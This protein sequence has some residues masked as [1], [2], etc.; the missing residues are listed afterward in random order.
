VLTVWTYKRNKSIFKLFAR[1]KKGLSGD[2]YFEDYILIREV[3]LDTV[4]SQISKLKNTICPN[5][6]WFWV[7]WTVQN[8]TSLVANGYQIRAILCVFYHIFHSFVAGLFDIKN[9]YHF[10]YP[11]SLVH[12]CFCQ[13]HLHPSLT[14]VF[15]NTIVNWWYK[16]F[17]SNKNYIITSC[18]QQQVI[19]ISELG[20]SKC[21]LCF[22]PRVASFCKWLIS[23]KLL[24]KM[25][26]YRV[27]KIYTSI[28]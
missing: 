25:K 16:W 13:T 19:W 9:G 28:L 11:N 21:N 15:N 18:N 23:Q 8:H 5:K 10:S 6:M 24:P 14:D 2:Q 3:L 12:C 27:C 4:S 7:K 20:Q 22:H 17:A 26:I 1:H